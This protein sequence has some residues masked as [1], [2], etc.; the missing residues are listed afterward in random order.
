MQ[1][2]WRQG[3]RRVSLFCADE[4]RP[5]ACCIV[6]ALFARGYDVT[7]ST[8]N[9]ARESL[10]QA[11]SAE[12]LR[13]IWAPEGT[14]RGM[15]S[16]LRDALDPD[17]A[18][19]VMILA[20]PTPRGV[21]DAIDA[22]GTPPRRSRLRRS[23]PRKTYLANPTLMELDRGAKG[24]MPG[25]IAAGL[26]AAVAVVGLSLVGGASR[27]RASVAPVTASES[28][29][30]ATKDEPVLA[31]SR[32]P[33]LEEID[34]I[35]DDEEEPIILDDEPAMPRKRS[36]VVG[37]PHA[38]E[39]APIEPATKAEVAAVVPTPAHGGMPMGAM[40]MPA[41]TSGAAAIDPFD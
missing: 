33:V 34:A 25:A 16:R 9:E 18:G 4:L 20:S 41:R 1:Q 40:P 21:I 19:D 32:A 14:D 3:D 2:A 5:A 38:L 28:M 26:V 15:R 10:R 7:L 31:S 11:A 12:V 8:G 30:S 39:A 6:D 13:V 23:A 35:E 27:E 29:S 22:F 37:N 17:S 24:W 36:A